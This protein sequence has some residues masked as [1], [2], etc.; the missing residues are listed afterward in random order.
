MKHTAFFLLLFFSLL[1]NEMIA[2]NP[3]SL[4]VKLKNGTEQDVAL[5][6]LRKLDF[7]NNSLVLNYFTGN[8]ET[9]LLSAI[10]NVTFKNTL[11]VEENELNQMILI[12]P[13][14]VSNVASFKN[15]SDGEYLLTVFRQDGVE[16]LKTTLSSSSQRLDLSMLASGFYFVKVNGQLLKMIKR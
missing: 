2:Q 11:G 8:S 4:V 12:F 1:G 9:Y 7:E 5:S 3:T 14:P 10:Q 6:T 15:L 13:N 16:I